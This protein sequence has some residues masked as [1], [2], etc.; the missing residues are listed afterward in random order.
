MARFSSRVLDGLVTLWFRLTH[1][2]FVLAW[3]LLRPTTIGVKLVITDGHCR[4][5]LVKPRYQRTWTLP[6]GG[7]HKRE[8]PEVAAA[9]ELWEEVGVGIDP[10]TLTLLGLLSSF[11]EGKSDYVAVFG[12]SIA[13]E[14]F[15]NPGAE[16]RAATF[17][18]MEALPANTSPATRRRVDE[19]REHRP[20]RG[21]W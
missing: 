21:G 4:V 7:V 10:D 19:A 9:R 20:M 5:L 1:Q 11:G 12:A 18:P 15:P 8:R 6:G 13:Y 2:G 3:K 16:N 17:F 14:P